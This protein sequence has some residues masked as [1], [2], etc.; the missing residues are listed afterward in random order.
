MTYILNSYIDI[1]IL[2]AYRCGIDSQLYENKGLLD[3]IIVLSGAITYAGLN[4]PLSMDKPGE[5]EFGIRHVII[6]TVGL[7]IFASYSSKIYLLQGNEASIMTSLEMGMIFTL[8]IKMFISIFNLWPSRFTE[9]IEPSLNE[10]IL[11]SHLCMKWQINHKLPELDR[12]AKI[13]ETL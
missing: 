11:I 9:Y 2:P 5:S 13:L 1:S 4:A 6:T 8:I 12:L 10:Q 7:F 3:S